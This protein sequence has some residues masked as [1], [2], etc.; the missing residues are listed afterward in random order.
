VIDP[1][2][3][4]EIAAKCGTGPLNSAFA[5][6]SFQQTGLISIGFGAYLGMVFQWYYFTGQK[7][8]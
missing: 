6:K 1:E 4:I 3:S 8:L 7:G 2:W 5:K